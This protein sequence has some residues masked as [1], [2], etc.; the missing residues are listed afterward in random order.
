MPFSSPNLHFIRTSLHLH[1]FPED[2]ESSSPS[3]RSLS[4]P[5]MKTSPLSKPPLAYGAYVPVLASLMHLHSTVQSNDL[6]KTDVKGQYGKLVENLPSAEI[7]LEK[8]KKLSEL[9]L[10]K[11][12]SYSHTIKGDFVR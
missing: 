7:Q 8:K 6:K 2:V 1:P 4:S 5:P 11:R 10:L 12:S 3:L 9:V